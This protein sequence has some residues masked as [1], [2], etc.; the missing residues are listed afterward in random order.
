[1]RQKKRT[2][3]K[4]KKGGG[5][6]VERREENRIKD[7]ARKINDTP[8]VKSDLG[9]GRAKI[10]FQTFQGM[11]GKTGVPGEKPI[12]RTQLMP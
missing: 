3:T 1:M 2:H 5:E 12:S 8:E 6:R 10:Q 7:D 4:Q 11:N 9:E